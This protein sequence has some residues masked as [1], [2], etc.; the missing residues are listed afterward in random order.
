MVYIAYITSGREKYDFQTDIAGIFEKR[1]DAE[2]AISK[3]L[4]EHHR[5]M[6]VDIVEEASS[7]DEL[8]DFIKAIS[9]SDKLIDSDEEEI[10]TFLIENV[11]QLPP[12]KDLL[13]YN[14]SYYGEGWNYAIEEHKIL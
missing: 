5:L 9:S 1:C 2:I 3:K 13:R 4:I 11:S 14:D 12:L 6:L 7:Q 10:E 8:P